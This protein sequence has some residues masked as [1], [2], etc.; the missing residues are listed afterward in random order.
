V[1][2]PLEPQVAMQFLNTMIQVMGTI[3]AIYVAVIVFIIQEREVAKRSLRSSGFYYTITYTCALFVL[4]IAECFYQ[5]INLN[6]EQQQFD[7]SKI[8][9]DML[10][11]TCSLF[12]LFGTIAVTILIRRKEL[13]KDS[14]N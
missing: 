14:P 3:L 5:L 9:L 1:Y 7:F 12:G 11:F 10:L 2:V 4:T 6:L 13:G 8:S